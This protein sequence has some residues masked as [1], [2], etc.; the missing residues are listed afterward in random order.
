[1]KTPF[2]KSLSPVAA[3]LVL[4]LSSSTVLSQDEP[5]YSNW[6]LWL[7]AHYS[8]WE[9]YYK[10][11]AEFDRAEEG[12]MPEASVR[13]F[14]YKGSDSWD[15]F[16][17]YYDPK[18]MQLDLSGRSKDIFWIRRTHRAER[19]LPMSTRSRLRRPTSDIAGTS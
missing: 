8:G 17:H 12:G 6:S 9:D 5:V 2:L 18:R 16:A 14:G 1:M 13:Y 10:K 3:M 4:V 15:L 19:C 11:T 7:G